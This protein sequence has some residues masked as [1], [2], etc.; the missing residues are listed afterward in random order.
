MVIAFQKAHKGFYR[1]DWARPILL[2]GKNLFCWFCGMMLVFGM[3]MVYRIHAGFLE[4]VVAKPVQ[5]PIA[6]TFLPRQTGQWDSRDVELSEEVR[7]AADCDD[8]VNRVYFD[9]SSGEQANLYIAY[10]GRPRTMVGH[11]PQTCYTANGWIHQA[12]RKTEFKTANGRTVPCLL[13]HFQKPY[14]SRDEIFVLN[15]YILNGHIVNEESGFSGLGWR[16]P[17]IKGESA[18]YV[19]QIQVSGVLENSVRRFAN[20]ITDSIIEILPDEH[21]NVHKAES[22]AYPASFAN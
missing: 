19:A 3:G 2:S 12:T 14:P 8:Y 18:F 20:L 5:L 13:H 21:R 7:Q 1:P 4:E 16:T 22:E 10:S 15:F 9:A 6:L 11:R 17:N